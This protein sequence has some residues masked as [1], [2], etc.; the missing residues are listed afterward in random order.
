[1]ELYNNILIIYEKYKIKR[2]YPIFSIKTNEKKKSYNTLKIHNNKEKVIIISN[3]IFLTLYLID[4][5][6]L[7][8]LSYNV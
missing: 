7:N 3:I 6:L 4:Q 1:M 8:N 2:Y 5:I